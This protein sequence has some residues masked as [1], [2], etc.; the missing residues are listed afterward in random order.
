MP[1]GGGGE[2]LGISQPHP[3][4]AVTLGYIQGSPFS[5]YPRNGPCAPAE[6][7]RPAQL[8]F[9]AMKFPLFPVKMQAW[10]VLGEL[11]SPIA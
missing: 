3:S 5:C 9:H 10:M 4:I 2:E 11:I 7:A 8:I 1:E 6:G